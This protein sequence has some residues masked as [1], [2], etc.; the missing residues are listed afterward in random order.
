MSAIDAEWSAV[1]RRK[2][3]MAATVVTFAAAGWLGMPS[4]AADPHPALAEAVNSARAGAPC[5]AMHYNPKAEHAADI[6]NR[7]THDYVNFTAENIPA[8]DPHPTAIAKDLGIEG[9]KVMSLQGAGRTE[10]DAIKGVLI[11]GYQAL[12]D[13]GYTDYGVSMLYEPESG[14]SLA[15][16]VMVG[17]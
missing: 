11:E 17:P 7:S 13:C 9:T 4:A 1:Y 3:T 15:V 12:S 2:V 8:D 14:Y 5:G 10:T 16:V 6:V